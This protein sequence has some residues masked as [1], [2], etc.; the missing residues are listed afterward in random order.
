[1]DAEKNADVP[2]VNKAEPAA[3]DAELRAELERVRTRGN[4]FKI[5]ALVLAAIFA[6]ISGLIYFGYR[7]VMQ[8][9]DLL[10]SVAQGFQPIVALS[11]EGDNAQAPLRAMSM[12]RSVAANISGLGMFSTGAGSALLPESSPPGPD[13]GEV[14][15]SERIADGGKI[16]HA[17]SKYSDRPLVKEFL[18]ELEQDPAYSKFKKANKGANTLDMIARMQKS[19]GMRNLIV[20]YSKRPGF[21]PLMMEVMQDP[22]MKPFMQGV[23]GGSDE[24]SG[25]MPAVPAMPAYSGQASQP[26]DSYESEGDGE[27]TFDASAL[28]ASKPA[29]RPAGK[30][31]PLVDSG[32]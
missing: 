7:K 31:P 4:I 12:P 14:R 25:A 28:G 18:A 22:A 19:S 29:Y 10:A 20:K 3:Q 32:E 15:N 30:P 9:K 27:I 21:M 11:G 23:S 13:S 16:M 26:S 2:A 17:L 6:V 8:S 1:M 5:I 24:M